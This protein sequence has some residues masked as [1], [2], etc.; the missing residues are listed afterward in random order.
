MSLEDIE[1]VQVF[2]G[3]QDRKCLA[4]K[5]KPEP[6]LYRE[7]IWVL[8][9]TGA[10]VDII[11]D[12]LVPPEQVT[13][14]KN[15]KRFEGANGQ[16]MAGGSHGLNLTFALPVV[17]AEMV[18]HAVSVTAWFYTSDIACH[19]ILS[20]DFLKR[21]RLAVL[22]FVD[23]LLQWPT[24]EPA[25]A[26]VSRRIRDIPPLMAHVAQIRVS[27]TGDQMHGRTETVAVAMADGTLVQGGEIT[28][29]GS[30]PTV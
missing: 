22:P 13:P 17:T 12:S 16:A 29:D 15:R 28:A 14:A 23:S 26:D 4:L 11:K 21:H 20:Y 2:T 24:T 6:R 18:P 8:V 3:A 19:A 7:E 10:T 5:I 9:D 25:T 27:T 1:N 30:L